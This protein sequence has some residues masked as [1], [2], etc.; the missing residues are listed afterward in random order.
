MDTSKITRLTVVDWRK[1]GQGRAFEA[2]DVDVKL[3]L[4]DGGRTLKVFVTTPA[5]NTKDEEN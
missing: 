5:D 2:W 1:D 4:Q 3:D